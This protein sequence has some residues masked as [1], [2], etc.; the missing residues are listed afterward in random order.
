MLALNL[1]SGH[2]ALSAS[3]LPLWVMEILHYLPLT[4]LGSYFPALGVVVPHV[5]HETPGLVTQWPLQ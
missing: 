3:Q 2:A 4:S 1:N 5:G